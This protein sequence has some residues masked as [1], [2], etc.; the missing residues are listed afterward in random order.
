[1][2]DRL[3]PMSGTGPLPHPTSHDDTLFGR[4][5]GGA[6]RCRYAREGVE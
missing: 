4:S 3:T 2:L 5:G 1:M 6:G